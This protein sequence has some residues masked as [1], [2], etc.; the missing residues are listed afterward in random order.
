MRKGNACG[1]DIMI[2][3]C[4][5]DR[6]QWSITKL[7]ANLLESAAIHSHYWLLFLL[8][9][10]PNQDAVWKA[11]KRFSRLFRWNEQTESNEYEP[12]NVP[13]TVEWLLT[14]WRQRDPSE[15]ET[16]VDV[17]RAAK[18]PKKTSWKQEWTRNELIR[19]TAQKLREDGSLGRTSWIAV[20]Y[21]KSS[22]T[23]WAPLLFVAKKHSVSFK[24][25]ASCRFLEKLDS[26]INVQLRLKTE[27]A[28][29]LKKAI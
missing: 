16:T 15:S 19:R 29:Y 17:Q 26:N 13:K 6:L 14:M 4:L 1:L 21:F 12:N 20:E 24:F 8:S 22:G 7:N 3:F 28:N 23:I 27:T 11:S 5:R 2:A 9:S 18:E 10:S 25:L